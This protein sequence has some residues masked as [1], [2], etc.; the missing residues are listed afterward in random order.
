MN[1]RKARTPKDSAATKKRA[2]VK[3]VYKKKA[4]RK[5][6]EVEKDE[7][8]VKI[9][10]KCLANL[11][12]VMRMFFTTTASFQLGKNV[13][14]CAGL[15][16]FIEYNNTFAIWYNDGQKDFKVQARLLKLIPARGIF[17]LHS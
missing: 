15:R 12:V 5:R 3:A 4:V 9:S 17:L 13:I 7:S 16:G 8:R 14:N 2:L 6:Q 10:K 11:L 1:P